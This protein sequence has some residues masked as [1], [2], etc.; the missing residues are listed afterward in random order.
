MNSIRKTAALLAL[1]AALS[2]ASGPAH[3]YRF[4]QNTT[5]GRTSS[6]YLVTCTDPGGF[7]HWTNA[8]IAWRLNT[9]GSGSNKAAAMQAALA[10]WTNVPSAPHNLTYA[11]TTANTFKTDGVNTVLFA[12]GN[13]CTGSCL[14]IT[15][16]VLASGQVITETDIS[17]NSRYKWNTNGTDYDTEAVMTH[18]LGHTL[19][20]HHTEV[21]STPRPTMY[22]Y[23]FGTDGRTLESDDTQG[24]QC[25][26]NRYPLAMPQQITQSVLRGAGTSAERAVTLSSRPREGGAILRFGLRSEA[27][28]KLQVFDIAGR[29]V[30]TLV[31]GMQPAGDRE[32]AWDGT[33]AAGRMGSGMYFARITTGS[34]SA[35]ATVILAE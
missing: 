29:H 35:R 27:N 18:E 4:I 13:G 14:A 25:S 3:A 11:G 17:F 30:A 8:N 34:G 15:A 26:A 12:R 23:Y 10:T 28:V 33:G 22:A 9:S 5:P 20:L 24:L 32:I 6:G 19:G 2:L 21:T 7:T 1:V 16:L 31:D